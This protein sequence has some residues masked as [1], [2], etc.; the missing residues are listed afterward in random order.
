[1]TWWDEIVRKPAA[2]SEVCLWDALDA[3]IN[4]LDCVPRK[5]STAECIEV[6]EMRSGV[7]FVLR[8]TER[9][10]FMR[11][12]PEEYKIWDSIDGTRRIRDIIQI[13]LSRSGWFS[14]ERASRFLAELERNGFLQ[15]THRDMYAE[16]ASKHEKNRFGPVIARLRNL[17]DRLSCSVPRLDTFARFLVE[18][19]ARVAWTRWVLLLVAGLAAGS[20]GWTF[21]LAV[22]RSEFSPFRIGGSYGLGLI[23]LLAAYIVTVN[24]AQLTRGVGAKVLGFGIERSRLRFGWRGPAVALDGADLPIATL[25]ERT[26]M[27]FLSVYAQLVLGG[28]AGALAYFAPPGSNLAEFGFVAGCAA[29]IAVFLDIMPFAPSAAYGLFDEWAALPALRSRVMLY[30]VRDLVPRVLGKRPVC[31]TDR[32]M[33]L[34]CAWCVL[35]LAAAAR[36]C[37]SVLHD[38]APVLLA[39]LAAERTLASIAALIILGLLALV[40][41]LYSLGVTG[42]IIIGLGRYL[43]REGLLR[44]LGAYAAVSAVAWVAVALALL[45]SM[46][47]ESSWQAA[48]AGAGSAA[49]AMLA[50]VRLVRWRADPRPARYHYV[51]WTMGMLAAVLLVVAGLD[52]LG[53]DTLWAGAMRLADAMVMA[54]FVLLVI[55][56]AA[57]LRHIGRGFGGFRLVIAGVMAAV[58]VAL[59]VRS[60][61]AYLPVGLV[62]A[63][64]ACMVAASFGSSTF[65]AWLLAWSSVLVFTS[66]LSALWRPGTLIPFPVLMLTAGLA[67]SWLD[68]QWAA[69]RRIAHVRSAALIGLTETSAAT[70]V[71]RAV[72]GLLAWFAQFCGAPFAAAARRR[73]IARAR[74]DHAARLYDAAQ[75]VARHAGAKFALAALSRVMT[76]LPWDDRDELDRVLARG[77]GWLAAARLPTGVTRETRIGLLKSIPPL[78]VLADPDIE[79]LADLAHLRRFFPGETIYRR[80]ESARAMYVV[81]TGSVDLLVEKSDGHRHIVARFVHGD[82]F[83]EVSMLLD[84]EYGSSAKALSTA[85]CIEIDTATLAACLEEEEGIELL[86]HEQTDLV[87]RCRELALFSDFTPAMLRHFLSKCRHVER[88]VGALVIESGQMSEKFH[89]ILS[90]RCQRSGP[91]G[92]RL[93]AG[94]CFGHESLLVDEP[95]PAIAAIE[96]TEL[97]VMSRMDFRSI[98]GIADA[99]YQD[100]AERLRRRMRTM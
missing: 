71:E 57:F 8:D 41:A 33:I 48:A 28:A 63:L 88:T 62:A 46:G 100:F 39:Q 91:S 51:A 60:G 90:G 99:A 10:T 32:M 23:A 61:P 73:A 54:M 34:F 97:L 21:V 58:T 44:R 6:R 22:Q 43:M 87:E 69:L 59:F 77:P 14:F 68:V 92:P 74:T 5:S 84:D 76:S 80:G 1:V 55:G 25:R 13:Y 79:Q 17:A 96:D 75:S 38:E 30:A 35:W 81:V 7:H 86:H 82:H 27:E 53:T 52:I 31:R 24:L 49:L 98:I 15:D 29:Y 36:V 2:E 19:S 83:G 4:Y 9:A 93:L 16:L 70:S 56:E 42:F 20:G 65:P 78:A 12:A 66:G 95:M 67:A 50:S 72:D 11:L 3:R 40:T 85:V 89:V 47:E 94:D 64:P 18:S 26:L 45:L 37:V